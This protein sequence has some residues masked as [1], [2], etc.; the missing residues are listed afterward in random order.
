MHQSSAS[1]NMASSLAASG[2][3][4]VG[5]WGLTKGGVGRSRYRTGG[6][7]QARACPSRRPHCPWLDPAIGARWEGQRDSACAKTTRASGTEMLRLGP[8]QAD[9]RAG[10]HERR[11]TSGRR[12]KVTST[13]TTRSRNSRECRQIRG[14]DKATKPTGS[15][16]ASSRSSSTLWT[17]GGTHTWFRSRKAAPWCGRPRASE[18]CQERRSGPRPRHGSGG[19]TPCAGGQETDSETQPTRRCLS[20]RMHRQRPAEGPVHTPHGSYHHAAFPQGYASS[21]RTPTSTVQ[22]R[23]HRTS[24]E[25]PAGP[26]APSTNRGSGEGDPAVQPG[27][28]GSQD[29]S[30]ALPPTDRPTQDGWTESGFCQDSR[31]ESCSAP[32]FPSRPEGRGRD[33]QGLPEG[34][35]V[36][37]LGLSLSPFRGG[38][39][40]G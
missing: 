6:G 5:P 25:S 21:P 35:S 10:G 14:W 24:P 4:G 18:G 37:G 22:I 33:V 20:L 29:A 32:P 7:K 16:A 30:G 27:S 40:S 31:F 2:P 28:L 11:R 17:R 13:T 12:Q 23:C 9:H 26:Q 15:R 1:R 34:C 39:L 19:P 8:S 38:G 3:L 36:P